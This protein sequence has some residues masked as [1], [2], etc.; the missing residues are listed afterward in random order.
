M[1]S[2][3]QLAAMMAEEEAGPA[4]PVKPP[5][6]NKSPPPE[7]EPSPFGARRLGLLALGAVLALLGGILI[8]VWLKSPR[9]AFLGLMAVGSMVGA[10]YLVYAQLFRRARAPSRPA[11]TTGP[12]A[13]AAAA[14]ISQEIRKELPQGE[15]W[16]H[17]SKK[18]LGFMALAAGMAVLAIFI[19]AIWMRSASMRNPFPGLIAVGMLAGAGYLVYW[20]MKSGDS[21]SSVIVLQGGLAKPPTGPINSL[22]IYAYKEDATGAIFPEKIAFEWLENPQGQPQQ[23]L[24]TGRWYFVHIWDIAKACLVPFHLPDAKYSDPALLARYLELPAQK[25]YLK[26]REGLGK[27]IGPGILA[28]LNVATFILIIILAG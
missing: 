14:P 10:A 6:V 16:W 2:P 23:C 8:V 13:A 19:G 28:A 9:N 17:M 1:P 18:K 7:R 5:R 11:A 4:K 15:K 25:K 12:D 20:Q 3:G 21:G 22:N 26:H 27:Y 24:N